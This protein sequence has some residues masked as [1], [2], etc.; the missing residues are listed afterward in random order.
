V[1][2]T[3]A[4]L[5]KIGPKVFTFDFEVLLWSGEELKKTLEARNAR[6]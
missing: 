6:I 4:R 1:D 5:G 3:N 2:Y